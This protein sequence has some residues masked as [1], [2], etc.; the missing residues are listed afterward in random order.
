MKKEFSGRRSVFIGGTKGIG[1]AGALELAKRGLSEI[2]LVG[3][4]EDLAK[5]SS[6]QIQSETGCKAYPFVADISKP[7]DIE[8]LFEYAKDKLETIDILVN[9]AGVAIPVELEDEDA[10]AWEHVMNIN[11]RGFH[12]CVREVIPQMIKQ[13]YGKSSTYLPYRRD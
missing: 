7:E 10:E 8:N 1:Y 12:L 4:E 5:T 2:V 13:R 11:V 9:N 6:E 3:I